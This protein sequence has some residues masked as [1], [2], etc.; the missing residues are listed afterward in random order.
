MIDDLMVIKLMYTKF[1]G[2][3]LMA[4]E[5]IQYSEITYMNYAVNAKTSFEL[6][7]VLSYLDQFQHN[8]T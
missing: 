5:A 6:V 8:F 3:I 2:N 1:K 4:P 7:S